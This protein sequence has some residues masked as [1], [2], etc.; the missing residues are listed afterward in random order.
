[1]FDGIGLGLEGTQIVETLGWLACTALHST[2]TRLRMDKCSFPY[3][4]EN[5]LSPYKWYQLLA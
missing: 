4:A 3:R 5:I 1:M 2:R